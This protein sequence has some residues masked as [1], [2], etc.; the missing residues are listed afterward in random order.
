MKNTQHILKRDG[1][2]ASFAETKYC[3][4]LKS[5]SHSLRKHIKSKRSS[6]SSYHQHD[7]IAA[8]VSSP[9]L[10]RP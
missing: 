1:L 7:E 5:W 2:C 10:A 6:F 4:A 8:C 9:A 3:K